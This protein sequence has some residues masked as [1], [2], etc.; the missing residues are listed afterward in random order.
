M[1]RPVINASTN[2]VVNIIEIEDG[3]VATF[4]PPPGCV[5]GVEGGKIGDHWN[6]SSYDSPAPPAVAVALEQLQAHASSVAQNCLGATRSYTAAG[7]TLKADATP[8][9]LT[10]LLALTQW[11]AAN[12]TASENWVA[13][14]FSV[15]PVTGAQFV[16]IA[17]LVG[18][19][20]QSVYS[21]LATVLQ[22]IASGAITALAQIDAASWPV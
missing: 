13:N 9:T 12:P 6:G 16:A 11:G 4:S 19:Y 17:P 5:I 8:A 22:Q 10:N 20:S 21:A 18:A 1:S 15:T 14:D 3:A 7:V 2:I